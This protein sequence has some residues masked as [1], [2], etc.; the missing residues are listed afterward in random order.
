M[1][2]DKTIGV[3]YLAI[4]RLTADLAERDVIL[5]GAE[6]SFAQAWDMMSEVVGLGWDLL[7]KLDEEA[8][9]TARDMLRVLE[10]EGFYRAG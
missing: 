9:V 7:E 10:R 2:A 5:V 4:A 1:L 3:Q 8:T 6:S